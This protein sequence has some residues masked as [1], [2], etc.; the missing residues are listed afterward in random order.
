[1]IFSLVDMNAKA[2]K[3]EVVES[4]VET[5]TQESKADSEIEKINKENTNTEKAN[6]GIT[7]LVSYQMKEPVQNG[8]N[9]E[10]TA[11][12]TSSMEEFK[13]KVQIIVP[14]PRENNAMYQKNVTVSK[15]SSVDATIKF[16]V[17]FSEPNI[18]VKVL[19]DK[20][21]VIATKII[22]VSY[23]ML[24]EANSTNINIQNGYI[25][26]QTEN[27]PRVGKYA[28]ILF[29][30][31]MMIGPVL[32]F[33]LKKKDKRHL[34]WITV[35]ALSLCFALLIYV[36]GSDTRIKGVYMG[37]ISYLQFDEN[38]EANEEVYFSIAS[39]NNQKHSISVNNNY[40]V[41]S[42]QGSVNYYEEEKIMDDDQYKTAIIYNT[43]KTKIEIKDYSAFT[44]VYFKASSN[45]KVK[46]DYNADLNYYNYKL[47]GDFE[48][49]TGMDIK[50]AVIVCG[51]NMVSVGNIK[52]DSIIEL[53]EKTGVYVSGMEVFYDQKQMQQIYGDNMQ[54]AISYYLLSQYE[55]A[56][57]PTYLIGLI[58]KKSDFAE[59]IGLKN[60]GSQAIVIPL[61]I[62]STIDN[63]TFEPSID[64][65]LLPQ[66]NIAYYE[67]DRIMLTQPKTELE[68]QFPKDEKINA[69]IYS[70]LSNSEFSEVE[71]YYSRFVGV[72][73]VW[74][75]KSNQ[76]DIL[77]KSG[78]E[79]TCSN[80]TDY[81]DENNKMRLQY[82]ISMDD[83]N[84]YSPC[85]PNLAVLKGVE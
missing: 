33:V 24:K 22:K 76:Y 75:N 45:S 58:D 66:D 23:T 55:I 83:L 4:E 15:G 5:T 84:K 48:N 35:P 2:E 77:F 68:Y 42:M 32:Y 54:G 6:Q 78:E 29:L 11:K 47:S 60:N 67:K 18:K 3:V 64:T 70:S 52:N 30:Y 59:S 44:S 38:K 20:N 37:Y 7:V 36:M 12:I 71:E 81:L 13:G 26:K 46:G 40:S 73:K 85:L 57:N 41:V 74:N 19:S 63:N 27:I 69:L 56:D 61:T 9:I 17:F 62:N 51:K 49:K 50:N 53:D 31:I 16:P 43:D 82:E 65:Y 34:I 8:Q 72:V 21:K 25:G 80:M 14:N 28:L 10:V 39:P 79:A 1:M